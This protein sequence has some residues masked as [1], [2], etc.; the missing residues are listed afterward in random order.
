[1]ALIIFRIEVY[2]VCLLFLTS[3]T[4][5]LNF[6]HKK[7]TMKS[8]RQPLT[9]DTNL[10]YSAIIHFWIHTKPSNPGE[11]YYDTLIMLK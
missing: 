8:S 4:V 2:V 9:F 5:C 11:A 1:M 3:Y 7:Y 6:S 10:T